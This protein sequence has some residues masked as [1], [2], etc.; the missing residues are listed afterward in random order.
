MHPEW[1]ADDTAWDKYVWTIHDAASGERLGQVKSHVR[2]AP[3]FVTGTLLV[4]VSGPELRQTAQGAIEEPLQIKVR[5][6]YRRGGLDPADPRY[7]QSPAAAA[8]RSR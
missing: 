3:H 1:V 5:F 8:L 2:Y 7:R 6:D 4:T